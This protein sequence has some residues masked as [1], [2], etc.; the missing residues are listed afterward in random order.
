MLR[1]LKNNSDFVT[2]HF[3]DSTTAAA[4][5]VV[6]CDGIHSNVR[7]QFVQDKPTYSGQIAYR[8]TLPI[9]GLGEWPFSTYSVAWCAKHKHMLVFPI[10]QN[11]DL[12]VVAF[13]TAQEDEVQDIQESWTSVCDRADVKKD[14]AGFDNTV[15]K[16]ISLM[17]DQPSKW[18]LNDR[19]PLDRW[20]YFEG[21]VVLLGD[22]AHAMLPHLGAG[23]G[24]ALEDGWAL[25]RTLGEH[26]RG[27]GPKLLETLEG[28]AAHY[29]A[30]RKP[31]AQ[32][33]QR[34]SRIAGN[35]YEMQAEDMLDKSYEEC[36]PIMAERTASRMKFVWEEDLDEA[37]DK[38]KNAGTNGTAA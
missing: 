1:G 37:Y 22:A 34:T 21:K 5:L 32:K 29:Q 10:S 19:E 3:A 36:L 28:C 27:S 31:R 9:G 14:F 38:V 30:V 16:I 26:L 18:R 6:A 13:V 20:H 35:T 11:K 17:P 33:V 24:Q 8:A 23:A 4:N 2:M 25:G 15:Q 7:N 12:N